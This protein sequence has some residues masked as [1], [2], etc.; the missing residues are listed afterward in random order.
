MR[1]CLITLFWVLSSTSA[2]PAKSR[3][4]IESSDS[5]KPFSHGIED[6][7][8]AD[9]AKPNPLQCAA[10]ERALHQVR[11]GA[12]RW[13]KASRGCFSCHHSVEPLITIDKS[14]QLGHGLAGAQQSAFDSIS[15]QSFGAVIDNLM[16]KE[17]LEGMKRL[18]RFGKD[19]LADIGDTMGAAQALFALTTYK[20]GPEQ[21]L[22]TVAGKDVTTKELVA[23]LVSYLLQRQERNG[24]LK[25]DFKRLPAEGSSFT[26][27][28]QA[29][30]ALQ[31]AKMVYGAEL[32]KQ[33]EG[34]EEAIT[35]AGNWLLTPK[36]NPED[37]SDNELEDLAQRV[38]GLSRLKSTHQKFEDALKD[39]QKDL[40]AKQV[41]TDAGFGGWAQTSG[42]EPD[43][44][45]TALALT[46]LKESGMTATDAIQ[47]GVQFLLGVEDKDQK[48]ARQGT[49]SVRSRTF[50]LQP[51][52]ILEDEKGDGAA[53]VHGMTSEQ[54]KMA[55]K[56]ET[57][58][59]KLAP[60]PGTPTSMAE[61]MTYTTRL[62]KTFEDQMN[63]LAR[64][65]EYA[66]LPSP[67]RSSSPYDSRIAEFLQGKGMKQAIQQFDA[68]HSQFL[69]YHATNLVARL[70]MCEGPL[71]P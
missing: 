60:R 30:Q 69:T 44:Y 58:V 53:P 35:R 16:D 5:N 36:R 48:G 20:P 32:G 18:P 28:A 34:I 46:A 25:H 70:L 55:D 57:F 4:L 68:V 21:K 49:W 62:K 52:F 38:M 66:Q 54:K 2:E 8:R 67:P 64:L 10:G 50:A 39:A 9:S 63:I 22:A 23:G 15:A 43:A 19:P 65:R 3:V 12:E 37:A 47:K 27:T 42:R 41:K 11:D 29:I 33:N 26:A 59:N 61:G 45:A 40:L 13:I 31:Q 7:A 1:V 56:V 6:I 51:L 71:R 17:K 24:S 14:R